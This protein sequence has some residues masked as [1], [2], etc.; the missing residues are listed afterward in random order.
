MVLHIC[1]SV[2]LFHKKSRSI[3]TSMIRLLL[4]NEIKYSTYATLVRFAEEACS[5]IMSDAF[6]PCHF[7]VNPGPFH[8]FCR[9]D[10]C[11]CE[12][13]K[14]CLCSALAAYSAACATRGV[15]LSWR[16]QSLCGNSHSNLVHSRWLTPFWRVRLPVKCLD[17]LMHFFSLCTLST[18]DRY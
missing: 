10:V 4:C 12:D 18:A 16:S 1:H 7:L 8:R 3:P 6:S 11:A 13:G 14:E 5:A 2:Y 9:Y 17:V 15:L